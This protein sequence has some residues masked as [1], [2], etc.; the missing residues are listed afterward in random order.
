MLRYLQWLSINGVWAP[1]ALLV[2][3]LLLIQVAPAEWGWGLVVVGY[4]LAFAAAHALA[5]ASVVAVTLLATGRAVRVWATVVS[6]LV[7]GVCA[8]FVL[9]RI[10]FNSGA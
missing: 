1:V 8:A 3:W 9:S 4:L 10:Y 6:A 7:G 5:V 2:C